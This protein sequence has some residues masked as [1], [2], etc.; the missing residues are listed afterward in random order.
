MTGQPLKIL[1]DGACPL[2][3]REVQWLKR[4]DR[5]GQLALEDISVPGFDAAAYGLTEEEVSTVLHAVRADGT[6]VRRMEA[7]REAYRAVGLGWMI[8]PTSWPGVR[9]L[10][11]GAYKLFARHRGRVGRLFGRECGESGAGNTCSTRPSAKATRKAG[12]PPQ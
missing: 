8:A 7:V 12:N 1:Y 5:R 2:C 3:R 10:A 11:D 4:R 9:W 6:V